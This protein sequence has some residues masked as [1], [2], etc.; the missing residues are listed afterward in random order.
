MWVM[1]VNTG[2][3]DRRETEKGWAVLRNDRGQ[4]NR[5]F[6]TTVKHWRPLSGDGNWEY[7]SLDMPGE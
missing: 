1:Q 5:M 7:V 4:E 6:E 2:P 3:H